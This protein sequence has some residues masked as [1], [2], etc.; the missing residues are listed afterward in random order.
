MS[1]FPFFKSAM[2]LLVE[3]SIFLTVAFM[4]SILFCPS[5]TPPFFRSVR[6]SLFDV[7]SPVFTSRSTTAAPASISYSGIL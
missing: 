2:P 7:A 6:A 5:D 1:R 3:K 4:S